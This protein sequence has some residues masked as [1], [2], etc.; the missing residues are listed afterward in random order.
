MRRGVGATMT[1]VELGCGDIEVNAS[2]HIL[3]LQ[4]S[5][6][7]GPEEALPVEGAE[8][9]EGGADEGGGGKKRMH[10][11]A[12]PKEVGPASFLWHCWTSFHGTDM[13]RNVNDIRDSSDLS[14][15]REQCCLCFL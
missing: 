12:L 5:K 2:D 3:G 7:A 4:L 8:D 10:P 6:S 1:H 15:F 9:A 11:K 13:S 14:F